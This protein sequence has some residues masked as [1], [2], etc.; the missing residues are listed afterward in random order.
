[1]RSRKAYNVIVV[2]KHYCSHTSGG[3]AYKTGIRFV[4]ANA[5]AVV[6]CNHKLSDAVRNLNIGKFIALVKIYGNYTALAD[7]AVFVN[8]RSLDNTLFSYH[9]K[10]TAVFVLR[11]FY[12]SGNRFALFKRQQVYNIHAFA[13][14]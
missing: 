11:Y 6:G 4:K 3:S 9:A 14:S 7:M 10:I 5:H 8:I 12:H 13:R 2:L 1:K